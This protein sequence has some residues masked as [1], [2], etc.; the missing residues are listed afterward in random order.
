MASL[1]LNTFGAC[2]LPLG[3]LWAVLD[4]LCSKNLSTFDYAKTNYKFATC[5]SLKVFLMVSYDICDVAGFCRKTQ[6]TT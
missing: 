4:R 2:A 3:S 1:P 6:S 5:I